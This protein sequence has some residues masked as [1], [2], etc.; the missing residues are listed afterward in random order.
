MPHGANSVIMKRYCIYIIMAVTAL[1]VSE[2]VTAAQNEQEADSLFAL[3]YNVTKTKGQVTG[4][5]YQISGTELSRRV[6]GDLRGRMTGMIPG[7]EVIEKGGSYF[8]SSATDF[9]NYTLGGGAYDFDLNGFKGVVAIVDDML[10]PYNQLLLE[11]NQI[12]SIT[13]LSNVLDKSK[14]GPF[15][16]F[17]ALSIKTK[18]GGYNTPLNVNVSLESGI[19][20]IDRLPEYLS[21]EEYAIYNNAA[22]K[23]AG[24]DP[25][26]SESD[27]AGFAERD[28]NNMLTPNVDYKSLLLKNIHNS[29]NLSLNLSAGNNIVKYAFAINGLHSGDIFKGPNEY[30]YD[31]I[32]YSGSVSSRIGKYVEA[33]ASFMGLFG[34]F[35]GDSSGWD[36]YRSVPGIAFPMILSTETAED[37]TEINVYGVSKVYGSNPYAKRYESG[38]N[39]RKTRSGNFQAYLNA[40]FSWLLPGL[41][42]RTGIQTNSFIFSNIGMNHDYLAYYWDKENGK[43]D[44]ST[45]EGVKSTSRAMN[46]SIVSENLSMYERLSYNRIFGKNYVDVGATFYLNRAFNQSETD[47][48]RYMFFVWNADWAYD[49]RYAV[50]LSAQYTG[51][52]TFAKGSRFGFFPS[53][54]LSWTVSNESFMKDIEWID[55]FRIHAQAGELPDKANA[56][57]S[58]YR[59]ETIYS[60]A[61]GYAYGPTNAGAATHWFGSNNRTSVNTS[62]ARYG[63]R[64]LTWGRLSE[65]DAGVDFSMLG[66][67]DLSVNY[68]YWKLR[69]RVADVA[70]AMPALFGITSM[71][72]YANY[73]A[74]EKSGINAH[75]KF[76]KKFR[77]LRLIA[78]VS[79]THST[80]AHT[81]IVNDLHA[82]G[83][84]HLTVTGTS[85]YAIWGYDCIGT[86]GT[87]E[88]IKSLP[89]LVDK[90]QLKVGDL[91]YRDVNGDGVINS[92]DRL[93]IGDTNPGLSYS[94]NIGLQYKGFDFEIVG[95]GRANVDIQCTS[96]FFWNGWGEGNYSEFV[97]DG[98]YPNLS[99]VKSANNF[100]LSNYWLTDGSWF[101]IQS[102]NIGYTLPL[103]KVGKELRFDVKGENLL[104]FTKVKYID[105]EAPDAGVTSRPLMRVFTAGITFKF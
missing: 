96:E 9:G 86:Y 12:E 26:Y 6:H 84:D 61:S 91:I 11:P 10:V 98:K 63:N 99:Y 13:V 31:R 100:V 53:M 58:H 8:A 78:G 42:S 74:Y 102:L 57:G 33:G 16:A 75:V 73:T 80:S 3:P 30:C 93:V 70:D 66:C 104:T 55:N 88:Q 89:S 50:E 92:N 56:T 94:L 64:S 97:K 41:A 29:T 81:K 1:C 90:S 47:F 15:G 59:H 2:A 37:G 79:M 62:L 71:T 77:D 7:L 14:Y 36:S 38:K 19:R 40:D 22:R 24:Y 28:P 32:T 101:K 44:I 51:T 95:T 83:D 76:D 87:E 20:M 69:D 49:G 85:L 105:P 4:N 103:D 5:L 23:A 27:I 21:G 45:H 52:D 48:E 65:V 17:G 39:T 35:R 43:T 68:F 54:G 34:A 60:R 18:N 82:E 25:L 72:S 67:I 46:S